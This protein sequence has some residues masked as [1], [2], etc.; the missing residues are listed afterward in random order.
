[1]PQ[2]KDILIEPHPTLRKQADKVKKE[3]ISS[4][5]I[6][7]LIKKMA[8]TLV[9]SENGVGLAAPQIGVSLRLFIVFKKAVTLEDRVGD[10]K[11][12]SNDPLEEIDAYINPE[13]INRSRNKIIFDEGCLSVPNMYG[14]IKR[15]EKVK[16]RAL[17]EK[18]KTIE[19]GASGLLAEIF[20]HEVDHLN[21]VL[22]I[23]S[24]KDLQE[25]KPKSE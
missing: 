20:Q 4:F 21:G 13:I 6:Q 9:G 16:I 8:Y 2:N 10:K 23:D 19:R 14:K 24:A 12:P 1:M 15:S 18:G 11:Q 25:Y 22:F 3:D 5:S 7:N 17:N